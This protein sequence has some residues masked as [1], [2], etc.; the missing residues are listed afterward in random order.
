MTVGDTVTYTC[1]S[2][3]GPATIEWLDADNGNTML[4]MDSGV[5]ELA[6]ALGPVSQSMNGR[7]YRCTVTVGGTFSTIVTLEI[8]GEPTLQ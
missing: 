8:E 7:R 4:E 2:V 5:T 6:L 1:T 3:L